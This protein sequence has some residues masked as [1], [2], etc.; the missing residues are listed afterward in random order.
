MP[1]TEFFIQV[2]YDGHVQRTDTEGV[3]FSF[4]N[5]SVFKVKKNIKLDGLIQCI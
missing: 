3:V 2:Y 4:N 5:S 1:P